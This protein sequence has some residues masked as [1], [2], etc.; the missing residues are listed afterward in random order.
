MEQTKQRQNRTFDKSKLFAKPC[1]T[2]AKNPGMT[3]YILIDNDS[4]HK[5]W[6]QKGKTYKCI[7]S[8][9]L[10]TTKESWCGVR[11]VNDIRKLQLTPDMFT[12]SQVTGKN[13]C[14][15]AKI[16]TLAQIKPSYVKHN[17][18]RIAT[19]FYASKFKV[20]DILMFPWQI[21]K[22]IGDMDSVVFDQSTRL[23]SS[24]QIINKWGELI[25]V[26]VKYDKLRKVDSV[27]H[28]NIDSCK[29]YVATQYAYNANGS[30]RTLLL[31]DP[32]LPANEQFQVYTFIYSTDED[33]AEIK[34]VCRTD[35]VHTE[36]LYMTYHANK[37]MSIQRYGSVNIAVEWWSNGVVKAI[38]DSKAIEVEHLDTD[39]IRKN[40]TD[41]ETGMV[42]KQFVHS[43]CLVEVMQKPMQK[44]MRKKFESK[45]N[46]KTFKL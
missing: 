2:K 10:R 44:S 46:Y 22:E 45:S 43:W 16:Q 28:F 15:I 41:R 36:P 34:Q 17:G 3:G 20:T 11:F 18:K 30:L 1:M 9:T 29:R 14:V 31:E 39:I 33:D 27:M 25:D 35:N 19:H 8:D 40:L 12:I 21:A 13:K 38:H 4:I 5:L 26:N 32:T 37:L 7:K 6:L 23:M 24:Y 42:I